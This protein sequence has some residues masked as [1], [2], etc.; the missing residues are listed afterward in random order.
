MCPFLEQTPHT[1]GGKMFSK[2]VMHIHLL[3]LERKSR[4]PVT[5]TVGLEL[6]ASTGPSGEG[7]SSSCDE[8]VE[9]TNQ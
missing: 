9:T 2:N 8:D 3:D 1:I 7:Q 4:L 6:G 5:R